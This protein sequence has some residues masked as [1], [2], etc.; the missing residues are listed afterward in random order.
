MLPLDGTKVLDLTRLLPGEYCSLMLADFGANV[1]KVEDTGRGDYARWTH[2]M[3]CNT[4]VDDTI[5]AYFM[6]LNRNKRSMKVN[7]KAPEGREIFLKLAKDADV[8]FESFRPGVM[9]RLGV[10]YGALRQI[11]PRIVYC[12]LSGYGQDGPYRET[13][14]AMISITLRS[15]EC[16][17]CRACREVLPCY[18][19]Y[20]LPISPEGRI[21]FPGFSLLCWLA[22][23][24]EKGSSWIS[25]CSTVR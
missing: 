11:N 5:S 14:P 20:K 23:I 10:G 3:I 24:Q 7:L 21:A 1:I 25:R 4:M 15:P 12:A 16:S 6:A 8:V 13:H 18:R 2:P 9:D 19:V 22:A 17:G